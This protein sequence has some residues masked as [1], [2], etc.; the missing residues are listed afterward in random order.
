MVVPKKPK[1]TEPEI[2]ALIVKEAKYRLGCKDFEPEFM[3]HK[4][5]P[6]TGGGAGDSANWD[7]RET[8]NAET[9][10]PDCAQAFKEAVDR[11]RR[12]FDIA[13]P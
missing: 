8:H 12:K 2:H 1:R 3:L 6:K 10:A 11:A 9:L 5:P 4:R 7:V 13:W